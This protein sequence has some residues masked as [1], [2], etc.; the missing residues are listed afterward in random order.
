MD[1][2]KLE[3]PIM[4]GH[5]IAGEEMTRFAAVHPERVRALI[6]LDAAYDHTRTPQVPGPNQP[7][8][9]EDKET[10]ERLNEYL[11]RVLGFRYPEAELRATGGV[12]D[13]NG[14]FLRDV[15]PSGAGRQILGSV[16]R[17]DYKRVGVPTL[18][19]YQPMQLLSLYPNARAFDVSAREL[20]ENQ[21]REARAWWQLSIDQY[22][23][24]APNARTVV[25]ES[26]GHHAFLTN[27]SEVARLILSFLAELP[28][29]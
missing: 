6:Y 3:R 4:V 13:S 16:E 26:G 2:L 5:S 18:A 28:T 14:R 7:I 25:L 23:S 24:E 8:T 11:V 21:I 9:T 19:I 17:P 1:N 15:T 29:P 20:A 10:V 27:E 22:R 12:F